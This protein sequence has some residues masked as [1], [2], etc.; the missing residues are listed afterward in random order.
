[1]PELNCQALTQLA[2][3]HQPL[4]RFDSAE[5]WFP[6]LAEAWLTHCARDNWGANSKQRGTAILRTLANPTTITI[7]DLRGGCAGPGGSRI[8]LQ[9]GSDRNDIGNPAY[10]QDLGAEDLFL[11]FAGWQQPAAPAA[12]SPQYLYK[13]VE[14][15]RDALNPGKPLAD[16][17]APWP[18]QPGGAAQPDRVTVYAEVEWAGRYP[19]IDRAHPEKDPDGN[20]D[21]GPAPDDPALDRIRQR[22]G[23][24][25]AVTYYFLYP[26]QLPPEEEKPAEGGPEPAQKP[27][28]LTREGQWEA[29]TVFFHGDPGGS[30]DRDGRPASFTWTEPAFVAYSQGYGEGDGIPP[31]EVRPW[32]PARNTASEWNRF[33]VEKDGTHP[34]A[35]VTAGTHRHEFGE[36]FVSKSIVAAGV[37]SPHQETANVAQGLAG[38]AVTAI[39]S[40]NPLVGLGLLFLALLALIIWLIQMATDG[41]S[42][43][44]V[45]TADEPVVGRGTGPAAAPAA[46]SPSTGG[47]GV[48][49]G[50]SGTVQSDLRVINPFRAVEPPTSAFPPPPNA[51]EYPSW[52]DF[53][54]RWGVKVLK[55]TT[56]D[57]GTHRVDRWGRSRGYWNAYHLVKFTNQNRQYPL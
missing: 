30:T 23:E 17:V 4:L 36:A 44:P 56:W 55:G 18:P 32:K 1:M 51:C 28:K 10:Q 2:R 39:A 42:A 54:G 45:P 43:D 27:A 3:E 31:A 47:G 22:L 5:L 46:G 16:P 33:G 25:L 26:I 41:G 15:L 29:I 14:Q 53:A 21:F 40:G 7:D 57:S 8:R 49:T 20:L 38:L 34:V 37:G 9:S 12:G 24:Y 19:L 13:A 11:D 50:A 35:Y 52:W 48:P 6:V